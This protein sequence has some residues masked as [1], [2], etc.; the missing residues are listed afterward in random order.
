M[1]MG[2]VRE[3]WRFPVKSMAGERLERAEVGALGIAGDRAWAVRDVNT[4]EIHNAK[5]FPILMQCAATYR[6]PPR[7]DAVPPVDVT[8]PDGTTVGSDSTALSVRLSALM[9]H[10]VA[11]HALEPAANKAF[12]R[13]REPGSAV[14]G[15][16]AQ[17]AVGRRLLQW[18][19]EHGAG[20]DLRAEFGCTAEEPLPDLHEIPAEGFEFYTPPGTYFDLFPLHLLTTAALDT[21]QRMNAGAAWDVRRFRPNL[22][23]ETGAALTGHVERNW[24]GHRIRIGGFEAAG[25]LPTVR[26]AMPTHA[27]GGLPRDPSVLRTIVREADQCLGLYASVA[28]PG[29]V[30]VGDSVDV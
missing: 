15:R 2:R 22:L 3:V 1:I 29:W 16:I 24:R 21:M 20:G 30:A 12:Y 8:L 23:I 5:R 17:F 7:E 28:R 27:Q 26:C 11:L 25:Q 6:V 9:G 13:R 10:A 4:G 18:A 19:I 14:L